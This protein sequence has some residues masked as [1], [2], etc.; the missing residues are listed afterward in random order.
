M[1]EMGL[2]QDLVCNNEIGCGG[3]TLGVWDKTLCWR[4]RSVPLVWCFLLSS[5]RFHYSFS[6]APLAVPRDAALSF[7]T[8]PFCREAMIL[9]G[10]VLHSE[11]KGRR[12]AAAQTPP[13]GLFS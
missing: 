2:S 13:L 6:Q 5:N 9:K 10:S 8:H 4:K 1:E 12:L 11:A 7:I 3:H